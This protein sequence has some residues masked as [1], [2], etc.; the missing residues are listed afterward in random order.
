M[1]VLVAEDD[2]ALAQQLHDALTEAAYAVDLAHD[3]E[4]AQ[5]L[6]ESEPYDVVVLDLGLPKIDGVTVLEAWRRAG[7]TTPVLILTARDRWHDKVAGFDSGADDYLTKPFRTEEL[8]ARL[9]A[10]I[11][12]AAGHASAE[13]QCGPVALETLA[14]VHMMLGDTTRS[15]QILDSLLSIPGLLTPEYLKLDPRFEPATQSMSAP[16]SAL[17]SS[18]IQPFRP[19]SP[20][21]RRP[22]ASRSRIFWP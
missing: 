1:R 7:I 2:Q 17:R 8:V 5:F 12:R 6:G 10:L 21:S 14:L 20:A 13:L 9:R 16:V 19:G 15:A 4:E 11:R 3:G 22:S 18:I